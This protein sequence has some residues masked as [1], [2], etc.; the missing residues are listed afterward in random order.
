MQCVWAAVVV[1]SGVV[2][3]HVMA[4]RSAEQSAE[5]TAHGSAIAA[6][7]V[8][9]GVCGGLV[10]VSEWVVRVDSSG[11][12]HVNGVVSRLQELCVLVVCGGSRVSASRFVL[13]HRMASCVHIAN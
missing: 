5:Q 1:S 7:V 6:A 12:L 2:V 13:F 11:L 4:I 9:G 3:V 10:C 8:S